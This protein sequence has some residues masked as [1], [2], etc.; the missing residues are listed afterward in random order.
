MQPQVMLLLENDVGAGNSLGHSFEQLAAILA[1]LPQYQDRLGIC[2]DTA[3]LWGAGYDISSENATLQVL[4][5]CEDTFGLTRL[6]VIHLNDVCIHS[7]DSSRE[8]SR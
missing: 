2:I 3:H 5:N 1:Q 8:F 4:Q 7:C 6:K